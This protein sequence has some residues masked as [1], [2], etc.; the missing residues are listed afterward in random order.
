MRNKI[1][2]AVLTASFYVAFPLFAQSPAPSDNGNHGEGNNGNH[3]EGNNGHHGNNSN[4][5]GHDDDGN[6]AGHRQ[7]EP[8]GFGD[9]DDENL[10]LATPAISA[11]VG[12]AVSSATEALRSGAMTTTAGAAIPVSAQAHTYSVLSGEAN[13]KESVRHISAALSQAGPKAGAFVPAL[14]SS[15]AALSKNP[16][17][18]PTV[19]TQYNSFTQTASAEFISNPP[20]EYLTMHAVLAR[21]VAAASKKQ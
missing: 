17:R 18:L 1:A 14:V 13:P 12:A 3:G 19:I 5:S 9:G 2:L 11:S 6:S 7:D 8:H 4:H 10:V 16:A 20:A 21:L 15:F